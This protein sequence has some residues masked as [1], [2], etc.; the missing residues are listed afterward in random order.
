MML[1]LYSEATALQ[2]DSLIIKHST[3]FKKMSKT[4]AYPQGSVKIM[5]KGTETCYF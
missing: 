2:E 3:L 4:V 5:G 1:C